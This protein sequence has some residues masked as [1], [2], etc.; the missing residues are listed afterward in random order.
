MIPAQGEESNDPKRVRLL[1]VEQVAHA[2]G[3]GLT[4]TWHLIMAG[5]I[6]SVVIGRKAR[7]VPCDAID[8]YVRRL[9]EQVIWLDRRQEEG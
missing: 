4:T 8:E 9:R 3:L 2:L 6:E 5:E 7:R 1:T